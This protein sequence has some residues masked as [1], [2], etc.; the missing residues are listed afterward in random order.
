MCRQPDVSKWEH[1]RTKNLKASL[2]SLLRFCGLFDVEEGDGRA[3][4]HAAEDAAGRVKEVR[5]GVELGDLACVED[6]DAVVSYDRPQAVYR[7]GE[8]MMSNMDG[9]DDERNTYEQCTG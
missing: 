5:R 1:F 8:N 9:S 2:L 4:T 3:V 7:F 6:T